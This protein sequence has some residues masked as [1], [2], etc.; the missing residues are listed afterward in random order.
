MRNLHFLHIIVCVL[1]LAGLLRIGEWERSLRLSH[2]KFMLDMSEKQLSTISDLLNVYHARTGR[3]PTTDEGLLTVPELVALVRA[4][5]DTESPHHR[6][7]MNEAGILSPWGEPYVYENGRNDWGD[8]KSSI[9]LHNGI[10]IWSLAAQRAQ[11]HYETWSP[12]PGRVV[13]V[14]ALGAILSLAA[15]IRGTIRAG[16]SAGSAYGA[17]SRTA[18]HLVSGVG[19]GALIILVL[20]PVLGVTICYVS[21]VGNRR[22]T[23]ELTREY[24]SLMIGFRARGVISEAT[25]AKI[26]AAMRK[27]VD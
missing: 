20:A 24:L 23:P 21:Y 19:L 5:G 13:A 17:I 7:R 1:L 10:Y 6:W 4:S 2:D 8:G 16:R 11:R 9:S 18:L 15:F 14:L 12:W 3:Y 25:Y 22:R 26:E 27:D